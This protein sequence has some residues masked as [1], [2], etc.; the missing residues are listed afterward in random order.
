[1]VAGTN[2]IPSRRW[3]ITGAVL[4]GAVMVALGFRALLIHRVVEQWPVIATDL[5]REDSLR[6]SHAV[7]THL[8]SI[9]QEALELLDR[10]NADP[11][12]DAV[13]LLQNAA[14]EDRSWEVRRGDALR[15]YAGTAFLPVHAVTPSTPFLW[16]GDGRRV[17][18]FSL[19]RGPLT[20][21]VQ[22]IV[23]F[24]SPLP[25]RARERSTLLSRLSETMGGP[26][27]LG[28]HPGSGLVPVRIQ[29]TPVFFLRVPDPRPE[30]QRAR[31][32]ESFAVLLSLLLLVLAGV[33]GMGWL[34]RERSLR[35]S[36]PS[37]LGVVLGLWILRVSL[38]LVGGDTALFPSSFTDP[39]VF[40][41]SFAGGLA[42]TPASALLSVL[43]LIGT[44][45]FLLRAARHRLRA[46]RPLP[47]SLPLWTGVGVLLCLLVRGD[48]SALFSFVR[49][50]AVTFEDT[51]VF[52]LPPASLALLSLAALLGMTL[53]GVVIALL[54]GAADQGSQPRGALAVTGGLGVG[55]LLFVLN[56]EELLIPWWDYA[57]LLLLPIGVAWKPS[58]SLLLDRWPLRA[59]LSAV[60]LVSVSTTI[61]LNTASQ[62]RRRDEIAA[63][64][65]LAA[66]PAD[67]WSRALVDET[68]AVLPVLAR[69][70]DSTATSLWMRSPLSSSPHNSL[71]MLASRGSFGLGL[72]A[73]DLPPDSIRVWFACE[74]D[75]PSV[76]TIPDPG[77]P[78]TVTVGRGQ[79]HGEPFL[80]LVEA[81][82]PLT[83]GRGRQDLFRRR[84]VRTTVVP[85]DAFLL[86]VFRDGRLLRSTDPR[87]SRHSTLPASF[88]DSVCVSLG[89]IWGQYDS[90]PAHR[91]AFFVPVPG[92]PHRTV[93]SLRPGRPSFAD[94]VYRGARIAVL[95]FLASV[96]LLPVLRPRS[97]K[98]DQ[99][100]RFSVL[101][102]L[103]FFLASLLPVVILWIGARAFVRDSVARDMESALTSRL[104]TLAAL[105]PAPSDSACLALRRQHGS[106]LAIYVGTSLAGSSTPE[107]FASGL[108]D[109]RL[110]ARAWADVVRDN[111][112]LAIHEE[113]L[114]DL[115]YFVGYQAMRDSTGRITAILAAPTLDD[116]DRIAVLQARAH[117]TLLLIA[118]LIILLSTV[119]ARLLAARLARPLHRVVEA[120]GRVAAG[121]WEHPLEPEGPREL[122]HLIT[123]FNTM[124]GE[125]RDS[126]V[127]LAAHEREVAWREMA[128]QVAHEIRN[129]LT[130]MK[131]AAQ[132][133]R[134]AEQD[135]APNL[136]EI[137]RSTTDLLIDRIDALSAIAGT[138]SEFARPHSTHRQ[139]LDPLP[140]VRDT[141]AL[142]AQY[143]NLTL[144][145]DAPPTLPSLAADPEELRRVLIN[146]YR[147]AIQAMKEAGSIHT[148]VVVEE[149]TEGTWIVLTLRD[150]GP[151]IAPTI[152]PRIFDPNFSTKTEGTG[153][154]LAIVKRIMDDMGGRITIHSQEGQGTE[155]RL[156]WR[157]VEKST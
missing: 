19:H 145:L 29:G 16:E 30:F 47:V 43:A 53:A 118:A 65:E 97:R 37:I 64:A 73:Q 61:I 85:E 23:D 111:A 150:T 27:L 114:G 28:S 117:A 95:C 142:F 116:V 11:T 55:F 20:I 134:R 5:A 127:R 9:Q 15:G 147:N 39:A 110:P 101:L 138:F 90:G 38:F 26:V 63:R 143:P 56:T 17:L 42:G 68:R 105:R 140:I 24:I 3:W 62:D 52:F 108:L 50:S 60:V 109:R 21:K 51:A 157:S 59:A 58:L 154:G 8:H 79:W 22:L 100:L 104:S 151:G 34:S 84:T 152:L 144:V 122:R 4:V 35:W 77:G 96:V 18:T 54:H 76:T 94:L 25:H 72:R 112:D 123:A 36:L 31:I 70:E 141:M 149:R 120:S 88:V 46:P 136:R 6:L 71:L 135:D 69:A 126:R 137:L 33:L 89:G 146:L 113:T 103:G 13:T 67:S 57:T 124:A 82:D 130:P 1:M 107:L 153:L 87:R 49:D 81:L 66:R 102:T 133:L 48:A 75:D 92:D 41:S 121:E 80:V 45:L 74:S 98:K 132:H 139:P 14:R 83:I 86:S 99:P 128:R 129:P 40:A 119:L 155:A 44:V 78:R 12:V 2:R 125:V 32:G 148:R 10:M 156:E 115:R 7:D 106:D 93:I 131:L 91:R